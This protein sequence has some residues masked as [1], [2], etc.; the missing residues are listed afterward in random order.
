[1]RMQLEKKLLLLLASWREQ[2]RSAQGYG[3][4][5]VINLLRLLRGHLRGLDLSR[6]AIRQAYLQG[7]MRRTPTWSAACDQDCAFTETFDAMTAVAISSR[8][9]Y[10]AAASRRGEIQ[11]WN[12]GGQTLRGAWRAHADMV[13]ALAFS[14]DGQRLASGSWDGSVKL[15]DVNSGSLLWTGRH[16]SQVNGVAFSAD[17]SLLASSGIDAT[18]RLWDVQSGVQLQLLPHPAPVTS[19]MWST[20]GQVLASSDNEGYIRLWMVDK[21]EPAVCVKSHPRPYRLGGC[22]GL[23]P[24]HKRPCQCELGWDGETVGGVQRTLAAD[25]KRAYRSRGAPGVELGWAYARQ[26][27]P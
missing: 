22:A 11:V 27:R 4:G 15:W 16:T 9:E 5:N 10:W 19:V 8:G 1:M 24:R 13:W 25:T 7:W 12:A 2:P 18:V 20:E 21:T 14:P 17:G 6:L 26:W 3:P 23:C